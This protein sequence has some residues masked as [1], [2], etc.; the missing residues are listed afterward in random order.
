MNSPNCS[1]LD[2]VRFFYWSLLCVLMLTLPGC[3]DENL[4][5]VTSHIAMTVGTTVRPERNTTAIELTLR[6]ND[7]SL[8][9][10]YPLLLSNGDTLVVRHAGISYLATPNITGGYEAIIPHSSSGKYYIEYRRNVDIDANATSVEIKGSLSLTVP[11]QLVSFFP[12]DDILV[13]WLLWNDIQD[14]LTSNVTPDIVISDGTCKFTS[15][16]S[17]GQSDDATITSDYP[18]TD[19]TTFGALLAVEDAVTQM[20][21]KME[22]SGEMVETCD[23]KLSLVLVEVHDSVTINDEGNTNIIQYVTD[24]Y[25]GNGETDQ[26]MSTIYSNTMNVHYVN[27]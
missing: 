13:R 22:H 20:L 17:A 12:G 18:I 15:G 16:V 3:V 4:D 24:S 19:D 21:N 23:F 2:D 8:R 27:Q 9:H 5:E 1:A 25:L 10:E 11:T 7:N 14:D 6:G 26:H